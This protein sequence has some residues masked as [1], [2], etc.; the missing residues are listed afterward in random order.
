MGG[1][2]SNEPW[3]WLGQGQEDRLVF[4]FFDKVGWPLGSHGAFLDIGAFDG[5]SNSNT[6]RLATKRGVCAAWDGVCVEPDPR[7]FAALQALYP[8]GGGVECVQALIGDHDGVVPFWLADDASVS[9]T[10][11]RHKQT[12]E[13][14][15]RVKYT[16]SQALSMTV[17]SLLG[18]CPG[19]YH[20]VSID[21]EGTSDVI[22]CQFDFRSLG[23]RVV[24]VE[25]GYEPDRLAAHMKAQRFALLAKNSNNTVW[26][27]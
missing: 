16:E 23:T 7:A 18:A 12:W 13:K 3:P 19:V 9:T 2:G 15:A 6:R 8:K 20:V 11:L 24:I 25:H 27:L 21:T 26:V 14:Q 17:A 10:D 1:T 22:A 4:E 5:V